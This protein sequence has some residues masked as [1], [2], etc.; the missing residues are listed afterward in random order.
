MADSPEVI[1]KYVV[2]GL[3]DI[4][5]AATAVDKL[6]Q[7]N[8][9]L[10]Q[11]L[12]LINKGGDAAKQA[13]ATKKTREDIAATA[14][15]TAKVTRNL[16]TAAHET[17]I[18]AKFSKGVLISWRSVSRI[19]V[20]STLA[21]G[22]GAIMRQFSTMVEDA[23]E[24]QLR[25]GEIRTISQENQLSMQGWSSEVRKLS[26]L[27]GSELLDTAE[28][29]Y[30]TLSNQ[31]AKGAET[32]K[33][34]T[35]AQRFGVIAVTNTEN[36]VNLLSGALNAYNL[37]V[38]DS[39]NLSNQFFKTIELGRIRGDQLANSFGQLGTIAARLGIE[40][41]EVNAAIATLTIQGLQN[42]HATTGMR[43][44]MLKLIRPTDEMRSLFLKWNV[45]TGQQAIE[46][47]GL[48]GVLRRLADQAEYSGEPV[49]E[50]GNLFQRIRAIVG[51]TGLVTAFD[52]FEANLKKIRDGAMTAD[53]A[54]SDMLENVGFK[55]RK[56][57]QKL[58]NVFTVDFG[59]KFVSG[60][61]SFSE[62]VGG[63]DEA[64]KSLIKT[65]KILAV[66][67]IGFLGVKGAG[68][69]VNLVTGVQK[70]QKA[71]LAVTT[72]QYSF[73]GASLLKMKLALQASAV[74]ALALK[75]AMV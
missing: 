29:Y 33:F 47:F 41:E 19:I 24:F 46:T 16:K 14:I 34:M 18:L 10:A 54:F 65:L 25:L 45:A 49:E 48:V 75:A 21:R 13:K 28:G 23:K 2:S 1:L 26:D 12:A 64:L 44:V 66:A 35:E 53:E 63:L 32:T 68:G 51:A 3:K 15:S 17:S 38:E 27:Y 42:T 22:I 37:D 9:K 74:A 39:R 4:S 61:V 7:A 62:A 71:L 8:L 56:E 6:A 57:L 67:G 52:R 11:S 31:I 59:E 5:A 60:V 43:N 36:S 40:T 73:I 72:V 55:F 30:Q 50:L 58:K 69:V 70:L 20:G